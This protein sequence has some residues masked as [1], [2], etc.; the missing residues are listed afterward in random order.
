MLK[1][2]QDG[3]PKFLIFI[4]NRLHILAVTAFG[5]R[6]L[7]KPPRTSQE[8]SKRRPKTFQQASQSPYKATKS[9]PEAAYVANSETQ[10]WY[11]AAMWRGHE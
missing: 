5:P 4:K 7:L 2:R 10:D 8:P 11:L 1:R 6:C 9:F 3:P